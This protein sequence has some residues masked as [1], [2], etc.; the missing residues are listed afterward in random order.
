[1]T[2]TFHSKTAY[3]YLELRI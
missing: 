3:Y 1:M 2:S